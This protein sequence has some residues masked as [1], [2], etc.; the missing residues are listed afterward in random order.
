MSTTEDVDANGTR[1]RQLS[2]DAAD[3]VIL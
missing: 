3:S 2:Q 1:A